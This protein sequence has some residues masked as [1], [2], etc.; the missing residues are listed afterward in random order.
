MGIVGALE[1]MTTAEKQAIANAITSKNVP[2]SVNDTNTVLAQKIGQIVTGKRWASG[3]GMTVPVTWG[4][5]EIRGLNFT[6]RIVIVH[7][8]YTISFEPYYWFKFYD[9]DDMTLHGCTV[10]YANN[11]LSL[12]TGN[13][14]NPI[15]IYPDGFSG[16]VGYGTIS[17]E[18]K[19]KAY[20]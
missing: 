6:P 2:A 20:E 17:Y 3:T 16:N 1:R 18:F 12:P 13:Y 5:F 7:A 19:W 15:T 14:R 10:Q 9:P 11:T 8:T 4:N